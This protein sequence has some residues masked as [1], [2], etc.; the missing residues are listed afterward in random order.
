MIQD[1]LTRK[2]AATIL[3]IKPDTL[4]RW[5]RRRII[6]PCSR[7]RGRPRY[8]AEAVTLLFTSKPNIDA[9]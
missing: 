3:K 5:E 2:E 4:R 8:S 6:S 1:F 9:K 7:L